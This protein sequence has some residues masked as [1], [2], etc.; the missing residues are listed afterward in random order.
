MKQQEQ[1]V[2]HYQYNRWSP[3]KGHKGHKGKGKG[4]KGKDRSNLL[5][6]PL[7]NRGNVSTDPHNRRLC[8]GCN[9]GRCD[10]APAGGECKRG[11]CVADEIARHPMLSQSMIVKQKGLDSTR[12]SDLSQNSTDVRRRHIKCS[13]N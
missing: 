10:A 5:P 12:W 13:D 7:Q 2:N 3:Y 6:R 1:L 4:F 9:L 11:T 8:F